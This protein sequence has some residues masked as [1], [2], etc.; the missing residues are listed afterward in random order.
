MGAQ[1]IPQA[2]MAQPYDIPE[3]LIEGKED[4]YILKKLTEMGIG[5]GGFSEETL[6]EYARCCTPEN[7]HGVCEDRADI[8]VDIDDGHRRFRSGT[9]DRVPRPPCSGGALP[10][11]K[12][13]DPRKAWP[14][15]CEH[16]AHAPAAVRAL[17][18]GAG[19]GRSLRGAVSGLPR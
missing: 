11:P 5:K 9:K 13:F 4:Y 15:Y 18:G 7:I 6:K 19:A 1:F 2:F 12:F 3:K 14:Q 8:A 17:S 10:T 16:R